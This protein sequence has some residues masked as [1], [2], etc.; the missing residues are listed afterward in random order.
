M[1]YE[2]GFRGISDKLGAGNCT[3][4]WKI[5]V[6]GGLKEISLTSVRFNEI[7]GVWSILFLEFLK[8]DK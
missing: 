4:Y 7:F 3:D 8:S 2:R 6:Q 1:E 5:M